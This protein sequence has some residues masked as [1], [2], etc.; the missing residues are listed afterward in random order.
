MPLELASLAPL[1]GLA[2]ADVPSVLSQ[3]FQ[4]L[5]E[6]D[7]KTYPD[8]TYHN[9]YALG[10]S[11]CF[12]PTASGLEVDSIDVFNPSPS[13]PTSAGS[14][15]SKKKKASPYTSPSPVVVRF[16]ETEVVLP[17][18][19]AGETE[20]RYPRPKVLKLERTMTGREIV[21]AFGEPTRKGAGGWVGVWVEWSPV[22]LRREGEGGA[23]GQVVELG[24]MLEL[25]DPQVEERSEEQKAKGMGGVWDRAAGWQWGSIKVFRPTKA[26]S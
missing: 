13:P 16:A 11:L 1:L 8:A 23:E 19:K 18:R 2:P 20:I 17:P 22:A 26:K 4:S 9:Y 7:V 10:L 25:N 21:R 15:S 6:P 14:S 12:L 3:L 24:V 5:S